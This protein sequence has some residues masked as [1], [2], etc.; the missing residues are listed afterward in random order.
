MAGSFGHQKTVR[1]AEHWHRHGKH[2]PIVDWLLQSDRDRRV[3]A[4]PEM[5]ES[6]REAFAQARRKARG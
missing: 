5:Y 1:K 3:P 2:R 4:G 6:V